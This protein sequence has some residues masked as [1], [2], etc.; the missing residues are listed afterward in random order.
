M[1]GY[2]FAVRS[3][4]VLSVRPLE[5]FSLFP[6]DPLSSD[7]QHILPTSRNQAYPLSRLFHLFVSLPF[8]S[9]AKCNF[10]RSSSL[11]RCDSSGVVAEA[12]LQRSIRSRGDIRASVSVVSV[13]VVVEVTRVGGVIVVI[14]IAIVIGVSTAAIMM[15]L[16]TVMS[17]VIWLVVLLVVVMIVLMIVIMMLR[18]IVVARTTQV[19]IVRLMMIV[20]RFFVDARSSWIVVRCVMSPRVVTTSVTTP[21]AA[22]KRLLLVGQYVA[23]LVDQTLIRRDV[24]I[25]EWLNYFLAVI[26]LGNLKG[27]Q[28][29]H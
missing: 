18:L 1:G 20:T 13:A 17:L 9:I 12:V 8:P 28:R 21:Q 22:E 27:D 29:I 3:S 15:M 23:Q 5:P 16:L 7:Q 6:D 14:A 25:D 10:F 24:K 26:V 11:F 2:F 4:S 19:R